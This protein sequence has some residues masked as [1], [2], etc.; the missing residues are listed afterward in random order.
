MGN[1]RLWLFTLSTV[2]EIMCKWSKGVVCLI[3]ACGVSIVKFD[4]TVGCSEI[5]IWYIEIVN[6]ITEQTRIGYSPSE[7]VWTVV[8]WL[9]LP[10]AVSSDELPDPV[11]VDATLEAGL[12]FN[13]RQF[14]HGLTT[15]A[16]SL[17]S[18]ACIFDYDNDGRMDLLL[19][20][21][22][23]HT[24]HYGRSH[25][26]HQ[27]QGHALYRNVTEHPDAPRLQNVSEVSGIISDSVSRRH[28][29]MGCA[30]GDLDGD[31][32]KDLLI[33]NRGGNQFFRNNGDGTLTELSEKAGL[34]GKFWST[35]AAIDDF[36][37]DGRSTVSCRLWR[38][39]KV[40]GIFIRYGIC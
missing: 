4:G 23:S 38:N 11:F 18:G 31:G 40:F 5:M 24:R 20:S 22:R 34:I 3:L 13:H 35:G 32:N 1:L 37:N 39:R 8:L 26:S 7:K 14:S 10:F 36:D 29:G 19:V 28:W 17:G 16:E 33:T 27:P 25:W 30:V 15:I 6:K 9:F 2:F 12:N 21:G